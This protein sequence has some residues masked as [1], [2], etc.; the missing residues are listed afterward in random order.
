MSC[1]AQDHVIVECFQ[2]HYCVDGSLNMSNILKLNLIPFEFEKK[3][4]KP[5]MYY[6]E[7]NVQPANLS[8]DRSL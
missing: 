5:V 8:L 4:C 6:V 1:V 3:I 2:S 7:M